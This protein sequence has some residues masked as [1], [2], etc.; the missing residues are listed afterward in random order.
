RLKRMVDRREDLRTHS[1]LSGWMRFI[2]R[3]AFPNR[4]PPEKM[5]TDS[6]AVL[7][8]RFARRAGEDRLREVV[9]DSFGRDR[10]LDVTA[11]QLFDLMRGQMP[12]YLYINDQVS[13]VNSIESRSPLLDYR[14][15][16]YL[17]LPPEEKFRNGY[18][19]FCLRRALPARVGDD[20]RW[21]KS[22]A[23][24]GLTPHAYL[25]GRQ[26]SMEQEVRESGVLRGLFD[27]DEMLAEIDR[28]KNKSHF[29][30]LLTHLHAVANLERQV[31]MGVAER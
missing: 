27:L 11:M 18:N 7:F 1:F 20:I 10:L 14:L 15:V 24:F 25:E 29:R 6:R 5:I 12:Y 13:M 19:K 23:G 17:R 22:K 3:T 2:R 16:K 8:A 26:A 31:P 21:R 30:E 4:R 28:L 9:D